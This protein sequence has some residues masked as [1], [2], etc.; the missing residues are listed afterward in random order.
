MTNAAKVEAIPAELRDRPQWVIWRAEERAGRTTKVPYRADGAGRASSTNSATWA[1]FEA[2][3]A[4]ATNADGIGFVFAE[5]DPFCG[6]DLDDGIDEAQRAGIIAALDSY[7]E[8]SVGGLGA[9]VIVKATLNGSRNRRGAFEVYD[10]ARF[11]VMTGLHV[12]GTPTTI[13][14]RQTELDVVLAQYLPEPLPVVRRVV[15]AMPVVDERELLERALHAR[16]G[17]KFARLWRGE[18]AGYPS[19]SEADLALARILCFWVGG[20]F[21]RVDRL[22]RLSGLMRAKWDSPRGRTTYGAET[23]RMAL[24]GHRPQHA[25]S[26]TTNDR[27]NTR[28][29]P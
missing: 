19:H 12:P 2:A 20:D 4:A 6:S 23:I 9:H 14:E 24:V 29:T 5:D 1:T 7:T 16:N 28:V 10:E 26:E 22:F 18:T 17:N 11:F 3:V 15:P 13:N 25:V 27:V 21:H 8:T